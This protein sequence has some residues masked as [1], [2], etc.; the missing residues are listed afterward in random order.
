M[1]LVHVAILP[2]SSILILYV[3]LKHHFISSIS[4]SIC[5]LYNTP[6]CSVLPLSLSPGRPE[7]EVHF[8]HTQETRP[9]VPKYPSTGVTLEISTTD[10][11]TEKITAYSTLSQSLQLETRFSL[12]VTQS[13]LY[14]LLERKIEDG[15]ILV[16]FYVLSLFG[17]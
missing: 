13:T 14:S 6:P 8:S 5:I 2:C 3:L 4:S 11:P 15:D 9:S 16:R 7:N 10:T 17:R 12:Y 1:V